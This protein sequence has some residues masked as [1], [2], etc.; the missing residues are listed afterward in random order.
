[1]KCSGDSLHA[2]DATWELELVP[3]TCCKSSSGH[4]VH[5]A[6]VGDEVLGATELCSLMSWP[7]HGILL[8][9]ADGVLVAQLLML[10]GRLLAIGLA[11]ITNGDF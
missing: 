8:D 1:M 7:F 6:L 4:E 10:F 9:I 3:T 5:G 2:T 11:I